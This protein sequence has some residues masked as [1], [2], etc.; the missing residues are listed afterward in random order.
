MRHLFEMEN[1]GTTLVH[2]NT[3]EGQCFG[4]T[5][6]WIYRMSVKKD[7]PK[8]TQPSVATAGVLQTKADQMTEQRNETW[9]QAVRVLAGV[10]TLRV[11]QVQK[12]MNHFIGNKVR[13]QGTNLWM[14]DI[15]THWVGCGRYGDHYYDFYANG[16]LW[17]YDSFVAF[18]N[19][20]RTRHFT[21]YC[22]G[23]EQGDWFDNDDA[24]SNMF[25]LYPSR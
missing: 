25:L 3:V 11:L 16:G 20:M 7:Q 6:D 9:E 23:G 14:V 2:N 13:D 1:L 17:E 8:L 4:Y 22:T 19:G 10:K 15:G 5:M 24:R 18:K 21:E 12:A